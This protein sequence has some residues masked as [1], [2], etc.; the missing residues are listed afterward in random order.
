M[1]E[2][3]P[4]EV[5]DAD[6][7]LIQC[8]DCPSTFKNASGAGRHRTAMHGKRLDGSPAKKAKKRGAA[9]KVAVETAVTFSTPKGE[10]TIHMTAR[11][12]SEILLAHSEEALKSLLV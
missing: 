3:S 8:P 2:T 7:T 9:K 10:I 1:N 6:E 4:T 11:E 12:A 5:V